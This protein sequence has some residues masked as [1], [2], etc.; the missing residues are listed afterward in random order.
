MLK[1]TKANLNLATN[2]QEGLWWT[3]DMYFDAYDH[4][5]ANGAQKFPVFIPSIGTPHAHFGH[6]LAKTFTQELNWPIFILTRES[7]AEEYR[8]AIS[9][10]PYVTVISQPD[11]LIAN[12]GASRKYIQDYA[13]NEGYDFIFMFDDDLFEFNVLIKGVSAHDNLYSKVS[14]CRNQARILAVWQV[15]TQYLN[16]KYAVNGTFPNYH[17]ISWPYEY[18]TLEKGMS[19]FSDYCSQA[20][21][22]NVRETARSGIYYHENYE[23]GHEDCDYYA[24]GLDRGL[25]FAQLKFL[26]FTAEG[27]D[28]GNFSIGGS[29]EERFFQQMTE[30]VNGPMNWLSRPWLYNKPMLDGSIVPGYDLKMIRD[31]HKMPANFKV[32]LAEL[33]QMDLTKAYQQTPYLIE[34]LGFATLK[35]ALLSPASSHNQ[36]ILLGRD[37]GQH[38]NYLLRWQ[39][40]N[41]ELGNDFWRNLQTVWHGL[42]ETYRDHAHYPK[43]M[44]HVSEFYFSSFY[45]HEAGSREELGIESQEQW[46]KLKENALFKYRNKEGKEAIIFVP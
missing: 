25:I 2:T 30:F 1:N 17:P 4:I 16:Q 10:S 24:R 43:F 33:K 15:A 3:E 46:D 5:K 22:T 37:A 29:L 32:D 20:V 40:R 36:S 21:C 38:K 42:D 41:D 9:Y 6:V 27:M 35:E 28:L 26:S 7:Q 34:A 11:D 8:R 19:T 18:S 12:A 13:I 44:T 14:D 45:S 31:Y 39:D 23:V